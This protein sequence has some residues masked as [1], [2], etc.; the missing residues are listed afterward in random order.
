[1]LSVILA[2]VMKFHIDARIFISGQF[3]TKYAA[4]ILLDNIGD[5]GSLSLSSSPLH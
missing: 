5:R 4:C 1:M 3:V 2:G